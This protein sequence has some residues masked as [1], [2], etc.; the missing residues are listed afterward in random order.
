HIV[1]LGWRQNDRLGIVRPAAVDLEV[2]GLGEAGDTA[3]V[4][5]RGGARDVAQPRGLERAYIARVECDRKPPELG[6][7][8][9]EEHLAAERLAS[10]PERDQALGESRQVALDAAEAD[11]ERMKCMIREQRRLTV[12]ADREV[13]ARAV[14]LL[15]E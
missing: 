1:A 13:A 7:I 10:L 6:E 4:H 9:V 8:A 2:Y 3:I 11:G 14:R 5:V 12:V 15:I